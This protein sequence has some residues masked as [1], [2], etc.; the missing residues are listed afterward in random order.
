MSAYW[1]VILLTAFEFGNDTASL[2]AMSHSPIMPAYDGTH[3]NSFSLFECGN[4]TEMACLILFS[5]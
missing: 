1:K 3:W 5:G 4:I 2:S